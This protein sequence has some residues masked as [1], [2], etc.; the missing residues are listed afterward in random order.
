MAQFSINAD[1]SKQKE[2]RYAVFNLYRGN[3]KSIISG[4]GN[5]GFVHK[6]GDA[7]I[8]HVTD[9]DVTIEASDE[10]LE[11]IKSVVQA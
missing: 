6:D 5:I 3:I 2:L 7:I 11:A 8:L 1:A 9:G 10:R 4:K